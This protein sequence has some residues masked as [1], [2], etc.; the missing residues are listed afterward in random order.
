M[1]IAE[2]SDMFHRLAPDH[3]APALWQE[4]SGWYS[5]ALVAANPASGSA[6]SLMFWRPGQPSIFRLR[7]A[8]MSPAKRSHR[9]TISINE[10]ARISPSWRAS[11]CIRASCINRTRLAVSSEHTFTIAAA[12]QQRHS[13]EPEIPASRPQSVQVARRCTDHRYGNCCLHDLC[14]YAV[15]GVPDRVPYRWKGEGRRFRKCRLN[16]LRRCITSDFDGLTNPKVCS[17]F[18]QRTAA[19]RRRYRDLMIDPDPAASVALMRTSR[20]FVVGMAKT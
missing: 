18:R 2:Q 9:R 12:I 14:W 20:P 1:P 16:L 6:S 7:L 3:R 15:L 8:P 13:T 17:Q 5:R 11:T 19:A 10:S 4:C